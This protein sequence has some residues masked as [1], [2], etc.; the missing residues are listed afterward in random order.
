MDTKSNICHDLKTERSD[1]APPLPAVASALPIAFYLA[2]V[3][4][5]GLNILFWSQTKEANNKRDDY[6]RAEATEIRLQGEIVANQE[7][8]NKEEQRANDVLDWIDGS[9]SFQ[10]LIV[11][12][13]RNIEAKGSIVEFGLTR[14]VS[15]PK[16][17]NLS[18][19]FEGL[20]ND[21]A[22]IGKMEDALLQIGYRTYGAQQTRGQ[23]TKELAYDATL[24]W[25]KGNGENLTAKNTQDDE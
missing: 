14:D 20:R 23:G 24:L 12:I 13:A 21:R 18:V 11:A 2:C 4:A 5:I 6:L 17:I 19:K 25:N 22:Q 10:P 8:L 3:G 7:A 16:Q 15:D 1:V 9:R